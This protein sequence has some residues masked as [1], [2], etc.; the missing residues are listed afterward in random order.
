[1]RGCLVVDDDAT[2]AEVTD[3]DVAARAEHE[4]RLLRVAHRYDDLHQLAGVTHR[5]EHVRGPADT[6][7]RVTR[8]RF[9]AL[10]RGDLL[11]PCDQFFVHCLPAAS[12]GHPVCP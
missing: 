6:E 9:V 2:D 3:E 4:Q 10:R 7:R 5:D 8:Q 1:M 12:R 11:E